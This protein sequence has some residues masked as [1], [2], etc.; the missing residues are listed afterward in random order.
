V[1]IKGSMVPGFSHRAIINAKPVDYLGVNAKPT[2]KS[3]ASFLT[4]HASN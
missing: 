2:A 3:A 4:K 1:P